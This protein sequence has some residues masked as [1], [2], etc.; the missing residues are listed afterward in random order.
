M[1]IQPSVS[2]FDNVIIYKI[3]NMIKN[4]LDYIKENVM[5]VSEGSQFMEIKTDEKSNNGL[6]LCDQD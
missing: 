1:K 3:P 6:R 4:T 5:A 2:L